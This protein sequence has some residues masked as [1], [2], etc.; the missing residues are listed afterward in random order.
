M[1][2]DVAEPERDR[3]SELASCW[4]NHNDHD[5]KFGVVHVNNQTILKVELLA[6][7]E[8]VSTL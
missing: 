5:Y 8:K 2:T 3:E 4:L 1:Y 7:V 6:V